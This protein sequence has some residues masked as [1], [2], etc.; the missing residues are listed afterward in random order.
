VFDNQ[1][2][3]WSVSAKFVAPG[4]TD[5]PEGHGSSTIPYFGRNF[6]FSRDGSTIAVV[7]AAN[8]TTS[9]NLRPETVF[10]FGKGSGTWTQ[11]QTFEAPI[12][13]RLAGNGFA[14]SPDGGMFALSYF[15]ATISESADGVVY[16][17]ERD[18]TNLFQQATALNHPSPVAQGNFGSSLAFTS[19]AL[20]VGAASARD[21][22]DSS[23]T[24]ILYSFEI[25]SGGG[26]GAPVDL[27]FAVSDVTPQPV[28]SLPYMLVRSIAASS[29]GRSVV[30]GNHLYDYIIWYYDNNGTLRTSNS[31]N[32][33][34]VAA[35]FEK[36]L[37]GV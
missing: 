30:V 34:G 13:T 35:V 4:T 26:L 25:L 31:R 33:R 28:T 37:V 23:A 12:T 2:N 5:D 8:T 19:D 21:A 14:L 17:F 22:P 36:T 7:S 3:S 1:N 27:D 10:I 29:D 16:L 18:N 15:T 9:P 6:A 24:G 32:Y 20:L 11:V